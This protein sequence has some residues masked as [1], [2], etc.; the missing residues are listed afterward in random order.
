MIVKF[1]GAYHGHSDGLLA[2]AGSGL[3]T[4]GI[5]ASPGVPA[6][7][8]AA[9]IVVPWNDPDGAARRRLERDAVAAIIAEPCPANMGVVAARAG[10]PRA[11]ARARRRAPARC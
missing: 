2:Q 10:L 11:A 5:P 6:A 1:A 8:A 3:A 9:T 4:Q 7:T